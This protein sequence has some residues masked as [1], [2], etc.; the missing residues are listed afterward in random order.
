MAVRSALAL[1][2]LLLVVPA[3]ARAAVTFGAPAALQ[4]VAGDTP[5]CCS[6][7][8]LAAPTAPSD[9]V[10]VRWTLRRTGPAVSVA[11]AVLHAGVQDTDAQTT[12]TDAAVR[13]RIRA[14]DQIGF[15]QFGSMPQAFNGSTLLVPVSS[16]PTPTV[17]STATR[18]RTAV[19]TR[20]RCTSRPA[21]RTSRSP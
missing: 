20:R 18:A 7:R 6:D 13:L 10:L 15:H 8:Y 12:A 17:T 1:V 3:G 14:G 2:G 9:G 5:P 11:P 16:S 4:P 21:T 19:P